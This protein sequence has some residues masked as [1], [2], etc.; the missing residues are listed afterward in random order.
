MIAQKNIRDF[1]RRYN[2]EKKTTVILTSHYMED[3]HRLCERVII[4]DAGRI[5]FDG[6]LADLVR[7]YAPHK[8]LTVTFAESFPER[9]RLERYGE[10]VESDPY[11]AVLRIPREGIRQAASNLLGSDLPVADLLIGEVAVDEVVRTI[12]QGRRG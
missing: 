2:L 1:L 11:K 7:T 12:F 8:I 3:I 9:S 4:I 10:L 6:E 5:L